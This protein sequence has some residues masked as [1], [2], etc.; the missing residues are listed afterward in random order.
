MWNRS[1]IPIRARESN[2]CKVTYILPEEVL[3]VC[4]TADDL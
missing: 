1:S 3:S 4:D 2:R